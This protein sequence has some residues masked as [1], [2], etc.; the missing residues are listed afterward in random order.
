MNTPPIKIAEAPLSKNKADL[1]RVKNTGMLMEAM[2]VYFA[3]EIINLHHFDKELSLSKT[4]FQK[5]M[6]IFFFT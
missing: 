6:R 5:H 3:R 4:T 2:E 1:V